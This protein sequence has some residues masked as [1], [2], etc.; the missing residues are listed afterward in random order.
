MFYSI[1]LPADESGAPRYQPPRRGKLVPALVPRAIR[2]IRPNTLLQTLSLLGQLDRGQFDTPGHSRS[3]ERNG[4]LYDKS[5]I[6]VTFAPRHP[7]L[8]GRTTLRRAS[9]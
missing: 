9:G 5:V 2:W 6:R 7:G 4:R 3:G 8:L 1:W